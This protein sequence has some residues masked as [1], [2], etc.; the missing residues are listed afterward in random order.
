M[1]TS[2]DVGFT[3]LVARCLA[4]P[5]QQIKFGPRFLCPYANERYD[6]NE[7]VTNV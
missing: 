7:S 4:I 1:L 6:T 2:N 3:Y 5:Q